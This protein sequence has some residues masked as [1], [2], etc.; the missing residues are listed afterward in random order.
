MHSSGFYNI[1]TPHLPAMKFNQYYEKELV[2]LRRLVQEA[3][4][5]NSA[6][7]QHFHGPADAD[8]E[9]VLEAFSFLSAR[10]GE[11]IDDT[12]PEIT[13]D[14]FG[15]LWPNYLRSFPSATIIQY[16]PSANIT[17]SELIKKGTFA[18]SVPVEETPCTFQTIYD[19]EVLP[20]RLISQTLLERNGPPRLAV[21]F[22]VLN[23][24]LGSLALASLRFFFT[25]ES[26]I[27]HTLHYTLLKKVKEI[28][29]VVID[30]Q[31][32]SHT[33]SVIGKEHITPV[34]FTETEGMYPY[35]EH[36]R[37]GYR[38][39]QEYFLFPEKFLF[40]DVAGLARCFR[41]V[42]NELLQQCQEFELQFVLD[43]LPPRYEEFSVNNWKLFC[44]PVVN[45]FPLTTI[46]MTV[47]EPQK[48][49]HIV[50]DTKHPDKFSI[51]NVDK[52]HTLTTM[53]K[54]HVEYHDVLGLNYMGKDC[55][56]LHRVPSLSRETVETYISFD[57]LAHG[58]MQVLMDCTCTN[59][60]LP[61]SLRLGDIRPV[62]DGHENTLLY[63]NITTVIAPYP[64]QLDGDTLWK[65]LSAMSFNSLALSDVPA[66]RALLSTFHV[67]AE[68][69]ALCA[70]SLKKLMDSILSIQ[71]VESDR[72]FRGAPRRGKQSTVT[73]ERKQFDSEGALYLFGM[74][75]NEFFALY[76]TPNSYHQLIIQSTDGTAYQW[77]AC[78]GTA[79]R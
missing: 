72:I 19:T 53:G 74:V 60:Q 16:Q 9:R 61:H 55:Y 14:L 29:C 73:L 69:E 17:Q 58:P 54:K 10:L 63:K 37:L 75:L 49:H 52:V 24:R 66:L 46:P 78:L 12:L 62:S 26:A 6:L 25:G 41:G 21:R 34:G 36:T 38:I 35:P 43:G 76:T 39:L 51:Y 28:H 15:L 13:H 57:S 22:A 18:T 27:A 44:T 56:R 3:C 8:I 7:G 45:L 30:P 47:E 64:P 11:K 65:L 2:A 42:D 5:Q 67:R 48:K 33:A 70:L 4:M 79:T 77:P 40:V 23:G 50:V 32:G 68:Y 71:G 1:K 20:L 59:G 31:Q